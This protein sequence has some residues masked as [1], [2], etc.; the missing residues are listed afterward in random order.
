MRIKAVIFDLD[1]TLINRDLMFRK[2]C[3]EL[4]DRYLPEETNRTEVI[5]EAI[6]LDNGGYGDRGAL[7]SALCN[8]WGL[9]AG[10]DVLEAHWGNGMDKYI[11]LF[12]DTME[13]LYK[14]KEKYKLGILTNG[15]TYVQTNKIKAAG[16]EKL[17]DSIC[18][19]EA[20]G[21]AKPLKAAFDI[22]CR[23]LGVRQSEAVYVG[24]YYLNDIE[25]SRKAGLSAVWYTY[26]REEGDISGLAELENVLSE[27][28][29]SF[30]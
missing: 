14:L 6:K 19:S 18:I 16:F 17:F 21:A 30:L 15:K 28:E 10:R 24:D 8:K 9:S 1:N 12:S 23:E 25:G 22:V 3:S 5:E 20:I 7:Y 29:N 13:I 27:M 4:A 26:K 11:E 2:Y